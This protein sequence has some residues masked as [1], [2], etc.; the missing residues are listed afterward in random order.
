MHMD[1]H[2]L[3]LRIPCVR[4]LSPCECR[5]SSLLKAAEGRESRVCRCPEY[6]TADTDTCHLKRT[7]RLLRQRVDWLEREIQIISGL[8][9]SSVPTGT[10]LESARHMEDGAYEAQRLDD[11]RRHDQTG[12]E[13]IT[14]QEAMV[15]RPL[16][17]DDNFSAA[18]SAPEIS[19]LAL[20]ATGET[21]YLGPSSGIPFTGHAAA[22]TRRLVSSRISEHV[23]TASENM[24]QSQI[25]MALTDQDRVFDSGE[26]EGLVGSYL[27]WIQPLYPLFEA[28]NLKATTKTCQELEARNEHGHDHLPEHALKMAEYYLVLALGAIHDGKF[29]EQVGHREQPPDPRCR[30][31]PKRDPVRLYLKSL[32]YFELGSSD[33]QP[34]ILLIRVILLMCIYGSH[35]KASLG[36]WQLAGIAVRVSLLVLFDQSILTDPD[37]CRDR[38]A[39]II[40][41]LAHRRYGSRCS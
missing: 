34:S 16:E 32:E 35:G 33:L 20:N 18:I 7:I 5:V 26:A 11:S 36:Q 28:E 21:S 22:I 4:E 23:R 25:S 41:Y 13:N 29:N 15:G 10:R 39:S 2:G 37:G 12:P 19:V 14:E 1:L 40:E 9:C 8:D 6:E 27:R 3:V 17:I 24:T 30:P 38:L 31:S